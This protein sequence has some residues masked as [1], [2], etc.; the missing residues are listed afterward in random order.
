[1]AL[2][3]WSPETALS[4]ARPEVCWTDRPDAPDGAQ[5]LSGKIDADL[6]IV[7][8][9]FT[10]LWA[11]IHALT[12]TPGRRVVIVEA[13]SVGCGASTRNGGMLDA[14]IAHGAEN[15]HR[16]W[17]D[18]LDSIVRLG[19]QNFAE[20]QQCLIDHHIDADYRSVDWLDVAT[21]EW[22]LEDLAAGIPVLIGTGD[23]V[24]ML[25]A[26]ETRARINSPLYI[27]ALLSE[28]YGGLV[29]P[30]KFVWGLTR[31]VLDLGGLIF[32]QSPV[33]DI[34]EL[35]GRLSVLTETGS[36]RADRVIVATNAYPSPVRASRR[37]IIPVYDH[38]LMTEPLSDEQQA[39]IGWSR[40]EGIDEAANQFH[41]TR[42]TADGRILWGGY[43]A[44]YHFNSNVDARHEQSTHTHGA[45]A[46]QFFST[47]PQLEGL[48]FTH[49]WG[50]PIGTTSRFTCAW[51]QR[52]DNRLAW[53]GG[54]TGLG[55]AASRFGAQVALDLVDGVETER[56][57]L[58]MVRSKPFPFPPEPLR[59]A[60]VGITKKS[61]QRADDRQ[62]R[63]N[64]WLKFLGRLGIG[65]DT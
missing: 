16:H 12:A 51:G 2:H 45:L 21:E 57:E 53:V 63:E 17:P 54:Y 65:F 10:G 32:E 13:G 9:G 6:V 15:A 34:D 20:L 43:D 59:S 33:V 18:E 40:W 14:S 36:V 4:G 22:Q 55:V 52:F 3:G 38:V 11:A 29:D 7:G 48:N 30:A 44:T 50:G 60:V 39:S 1:M 62:G 35:D 26:D 46:E 41:Y 24:R 25:D 42:R 49:R 58:E 19:D 28:G 37:R 56:T 27:G 8:G 23:S 47:F 61:I 64:V 5:R 31:L